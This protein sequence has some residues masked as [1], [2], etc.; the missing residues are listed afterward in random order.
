MNEKIIEIISEYRKETE[1][2][3]YFINYSDETPDILD[4]KIGGMPYLPIDEEYPKDKY[5]NPMALFIQINFR[6]LNLENYPKGIFEL[7]ITTNEDDIYEDLELSEDCYAIR[8]Y[9]EGLGYQTELPKINI[10]DF[11]Y[12][13]PVKIELTKGKTHLPYNMGDNKAINIL[14]DLFEE[15]FNTKINYPMELKDKF[16]V[17]YYDLIDKLNDNSV[18]YSNVG[19]YVNFINDP[20][21][22]YDINDESIVIYSDLDKGICFGADAGSFYILIKK[23]DLLNKNFDKATCNFEF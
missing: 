18:Y 12:K 20:D 19:G 4:D 21:L 17:D 8:F 7:F 1:K 11:L 9:E 10:K 13:N 22:N 5:G 2:E 3:C 16:N 6:K 23:E 14:L 15:K